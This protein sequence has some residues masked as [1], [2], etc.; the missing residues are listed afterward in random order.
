[1]DHTTKGNEN[2]IMLG[3]FNGTMNKIDRHGGNKTKTL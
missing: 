1:M 3:D 2:K